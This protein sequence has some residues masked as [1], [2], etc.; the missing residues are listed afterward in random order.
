MKFGFDRE[1]RCKNH[2]N[3]NGGGGKQNGGGKNPIPGPG[4]E[5][6]NRRLNYTIF[7][8]NKSEC[9]KEKG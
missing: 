9:C 1:K 4:K 3:S 5:C 8:P 6:C 7:N 2:Q